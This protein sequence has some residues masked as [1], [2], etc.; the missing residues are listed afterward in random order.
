MVV[1]PILISCSREYSWAIPTYIL[2]WGFC[3]HCLRWWQRD[4]GRWRC[5][6]SISLC[7]LFRIWFLIGLAERVISNHR[8][9]KYWIKYSVN[10]YR[11]YHSAQ[12]ELVWVIY[13]IPAASSQPPTSS[14]S[15]SPLRCQLWSF[16][17]W[18]CSSLQ[19]VIRWNWFSS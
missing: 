6:M 3:L 4:E 7:D 13:C 15:S 1:P 12:E 10:N 9:R 5:K 14:T 18:G 8:Y 16:S 17:S 19:V 11:N 2:S